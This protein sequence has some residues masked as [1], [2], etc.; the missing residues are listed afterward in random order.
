MALTKRPGENA[1]DVA[2]AVLARVASLKDTV[3]P[4]D[5][6]V[7]EARND[8]ATANDKAVKLMQELRWP[9]PPSWR[10]YSSRWAGAGPRSSVAQWS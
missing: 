4:H 6:Q 8:G 7:A 9:P 5:V 1:I 3:I 2:E 10:W